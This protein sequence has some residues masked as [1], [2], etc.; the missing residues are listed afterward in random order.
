MCEAKR[1]D[2]GWAGLAQEPSGRREEKLFFRIMIA[3]Q[4]RRC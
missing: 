3:I 1:M 4:E 2:V